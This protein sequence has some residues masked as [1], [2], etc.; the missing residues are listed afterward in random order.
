MC[1]DGGCWGWGLKQIHLSIS[2]TIDKQIREIKTNN[3]A[4]VRLKVEVEDHLYSHFT[5]PPKQTGEKT[6]KHFNAKLGVKQSC[7]FDS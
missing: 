6:V 7:S 4:R 1:V 3:D 2:R 5:P